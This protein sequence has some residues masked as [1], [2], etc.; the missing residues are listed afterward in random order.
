MPDKKQQSNTLYINYLYYN[1]LFGTCTVL[2]DLSEVLKAATSLQA[3]WESFATVLGMKQDTIERIQQ[4]H[5]RDSAFCLKEVLKEW[6]KK[7]YDTFRHG[8]P[9]WRNICEAT[10][11]EIG[12]N[13]K[14]LAEEIA[15]QHPAQKKST[16]EEGKGT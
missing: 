8:H 4:D 3:K 7:N 2:A 13:N 11:S 9:S 5:P 6:L 14:Q 15:K 16:I 10:A 1:L 12:G